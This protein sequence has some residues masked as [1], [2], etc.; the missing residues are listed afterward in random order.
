MAPPLTGSS[1]IRIRQF[2]G[3]MTTLY[4]QNSF[5]GKH[6]VNRIKHLRLRSFGAVGL[7][8]TVAQSPEPK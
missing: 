5:A 6:G 3:Q 7:N 8:Q 2:K 4:P 1:L